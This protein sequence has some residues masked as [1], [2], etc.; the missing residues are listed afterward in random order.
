MR[1]LALPRLDARIH[2]RLAEGVQA[3]GDDP[4][5]VALLARRALEQAVEVRQV[6]VLVAG[7]T[8]A[9][10]AAR[11]A[12]GDA[13]LQPAHL[14]VEDR[15]ALLG[16]RP[17]AALVVERRKVRGA[18]RLGGRLA[19]LELRGAPLEHAAVALGLGK[20]GRVRLHGAAQRARLLLGLHQLLLQALFGVRVALDHLA[21]ALGAAR[22]RAQL[23]LDR[24]LG[25]HRRKV[26]VVR[27]AL[28]G[29]EPHNLVLELREVH[30][31]RVRLLVERIV[32]G[33]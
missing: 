29:R 24:I 20:L 19:A 7:A 16:P 32:R 28:L 26:L 25:A 12:V 33:A 18:A 30:E 6:R 22:E 3:L 23:G 15:R 13:P 21:L 9:H 1:A 17:R 11:V 5:A 4:V 31:L 14:L 2:T 8:L 10:G 27:L